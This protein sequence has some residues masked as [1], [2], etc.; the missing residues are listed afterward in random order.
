MF[1]FL[2]KFDQRGF[3]LVETVL[4]LAIVGI[5]LVA[6]VDFNLTLSGT[7]SK[8]G[9][10]IKTSQNRRSTLSAID[11]LARNADGLLRDVN[12]YCL[13]SSTLALYFAS[14]DYLPGTCVESGGGVKIY[15]D[16]NRVKLSCYP[17]IAYNG[18]YGACEATVGNSYYLSSPEINI[19]SGGLVFATSTATSTFSSFMNI[20]T[21]LTLTNIDN[22]QSELSAESI[23]SST[24]TLRNQQLDALVAWWKFDDAVATGAIDSQ[25][26]YDAD[27]RDTS[28][29][30]TP[31]VRG[32][33]F[34]FDFER[35]V[36]PNCYSVDS[37]FNISGP[38][39]MSTWIL[40]ESLSIDSSDDFIINK[41][42]TASYLGYAMWV[43]DNR[44]YCGV[45]DGAVCMEDYEQGG[46]IYVGETYHVTCSY[47]PSIDQMK[48]YIFQEGIGNL[49]TTTIATTQNLVNYTGDFYI[50]NRG[51]SAVSFDGLIDEMRIYNRKLSDQEI[52]AL[53]SQG[54]VVN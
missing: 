43:R 47:D 36:N 51:G 6:V 41:Q 34:S 9:A 17:N 20:S 32:S 37:V 12:G 26:G 8:L 4:Y 48:L 50:D 27:C 1:S 18:W 52:W 2:K 22:G 21:L 44:L 5:L 30:A 40:P 42:N 39:T 16:N 46:R 33:N 10:N 28:A 45:C 23:A 11:Y 24:I 14:D 53:Q 25:N 13:T 29:E 7:A 3:S 38:F 31:L 54:A 49:G 15:T 19:A 35:D